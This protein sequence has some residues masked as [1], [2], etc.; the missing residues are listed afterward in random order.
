MPSQATNYF[1]TLAAMGV[2]ALIITNV[3]ELQVN[4]IEASA[5]RLELL[6]ILEAIAAESTELITLTE[7][8]G[9]STKIAV[10]MPQRIGDKQYWVRLR[11]SH[12]GSWV[13]GGFGE[14]WTGIPDLRVYL[15]WNT[16]STGTYKGGYGNL[17]LNCTVD[18][19][20]PYLILNR[21][22]EA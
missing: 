16:T 21:W 4:Q 18:A 7:S 9:S 14:P 3:F 1:Y 8:T 20:E 5:E 6:E 22:E 19:G 15:P 11:T 17:S 10:H 2:V 13:E 12:E